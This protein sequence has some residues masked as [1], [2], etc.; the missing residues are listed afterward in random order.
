MI[1]TSHIE[2]SNLTMR[3]QIK[4]LARLTL[5]FSKS[6]K[7]LVRHCA[8]LRLLQLLPDSFQFAGYPAMESNL[9]DHIWTTRELLN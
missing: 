5:S 8:P 7:P 9:T 4:R 6:A 1:S 2:L 3:T